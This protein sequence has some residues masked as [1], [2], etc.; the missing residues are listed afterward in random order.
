M[1]HDPKLIDRVEQVIAEELLQL[2]N[3][4]GSPDNVTI[5]PLRLLS[6]NGA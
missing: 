3:Q 1:A 2:A 5:L 6:V 4:R